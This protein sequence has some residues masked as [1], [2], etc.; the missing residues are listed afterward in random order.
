MDEWKRSDVFHLGD[1]LTQHPLT[2]VIIFILHWLF[3]P[4]LLKVAEILE[5]LLHSE[6][7]ICNK[8]LYA[9]PWNCWN[10]L[11]FFLLLP[12]QVCAYRKNFS[13]IK[14]SV[15]LSELPPMLKSFL[16]KASSFTLLTLRP[17]V[18]NRLFFWWFSHTF[19]F[20]FLLFFAFWFFKC[21]C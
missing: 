5:S 1:E 3:M 20:G 12:Y 7:K 21:H 2:K 17:H 16:H 4:L 11:I 10:C 13:C 9:V 6:N 19:G 8:N 15:T 14:S 18:C